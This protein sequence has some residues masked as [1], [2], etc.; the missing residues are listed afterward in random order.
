MPRCRM[1]A[2]SLRI[3]FEALSCT[4]RTRNVTT[5][6][7]RPESFPLERLCS[8]DGS[9]FSSGGGGTGD[10]HAR[11]SSAGA[12]GPVGGIEESR[13]KERSLGGTPPPPPVL[14]PASP[15]VCSSKPGSQ[16][17]DYTTSQ[18]L[19]VSPFLSS[20]TYGSTYG[21][22]GGIGAT[23]SSPGGW[24][25]TSGGLSGTELS[26]ILGGGLLAAA[27]GSLDE[28]VTMLRDRI[29]QVARAAERAEGAKEHQARSYK[30]ELKRMQARAF[31]HPHLRE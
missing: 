24:T 12:D 1:F 20:S 10:T 26:S 28:E 17:I 30:T 2:E 23:R 13:I 15:H 14:P 31:C 29:V 6:A 25:G 22:L 18:P 27:P 16:Y 11:S 5:F 9:K 4:A 21:L 7:R 8:E 19:S 3:H